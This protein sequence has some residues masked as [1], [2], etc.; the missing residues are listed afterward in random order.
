MATIGQ[1][2]VALFTI[3]GTTIFSYTL[4]RFQPIDS[5]SQGWGDGSCGRRGNQ[6]EDRGLIQNEAVA[7][8]TS[9]RVG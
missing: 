2:R 6:Y 7:V 9:I 8:I 4:R 1:R 5:T 3:Q